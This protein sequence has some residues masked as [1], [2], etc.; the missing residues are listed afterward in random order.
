MSD[1]EKPIASGR[2]PAGINP[3]ESPFEL[4]PIEG[5]P[6]TRKEREELRRTIREFDRERATSAE[7]TR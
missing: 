2:P 4:Q 7:G 5:L 3:D 1:E 6:L